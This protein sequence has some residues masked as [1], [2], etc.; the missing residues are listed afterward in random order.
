MISAYFT[1]FVFDEIFH[2][3]CCKNVEFF[4][5][6]YDLYDW[7]V[8]IYQFPNVFN[9]IKDEMLPKTWQQVQCI[10]YLV[11]LTRINTF[12]RLVFQTINGIFKSGFWKYRSIVS[13]YIKYGSVV[14]SQILLIIS[15][16]TWPFIKIEFVIYN[17]R[18]Q[19]MLDI[20]TFLHDYW[21]VL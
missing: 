16:L 20:D 13:S 7:N 17:F 11:N 14:R 4:W 6:T 9:I 19:Q 18:F 1:P 5:F 3:F 10:Y 12:L 8:I 2:R 15:V 21:K